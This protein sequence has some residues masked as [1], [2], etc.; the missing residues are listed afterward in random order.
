MIGQMNRPKRSGFTFIEL[1][2][3]IGL[4][5]GVAGLLLPAVQQARESQGHAQSQ[6]SQGH[7]LRSRA[8]LP[9][10]IYPV[11]RCACGA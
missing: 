5:A 3:V 4:I 10:Q 7:A 1:L 9:R 8:E 6:E 2:V 11:R